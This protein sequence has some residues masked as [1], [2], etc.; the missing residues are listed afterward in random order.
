MWGRSG[1]EQARKETSKLE[2]IVR[3][4]RKWRCGRDEGRVEAPCPG[5]PHAWPV[6]GRPGPSR[7]WRQE[8]C[9]AGASRAA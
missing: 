3:G 9:Q 4:E 1:P 8:Q 5:P 2:H 6:W 7:A